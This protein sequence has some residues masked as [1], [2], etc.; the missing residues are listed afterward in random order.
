MRSSDW[1]ADSRLR[2]HFLRT[3]AAVVVVVVVVVAHHF[4]R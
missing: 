1:S 2:S 3:N 4:H